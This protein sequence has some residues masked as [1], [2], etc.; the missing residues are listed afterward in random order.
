M[1]GSVIDRPGRYFS[2]KIRY[3]SPD[4]VTISTGLTSKLFIFAWGDYADTPH[5]AGQSRQ[6]NHRLLLYVMRK[7]RIQKQYGKT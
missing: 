2:P 3:T 1:H 6:Y 5:L 4:S 7:C